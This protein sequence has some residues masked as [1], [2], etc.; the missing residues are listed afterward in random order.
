MHGDRRQPLLTC[1]EMEFLL[2]DLE[3]G[4]GGSSLPPPSHGEGE[5]WRW[6]GTVTG[7]ADSCTWDVL[8]TLGGLF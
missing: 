2:W 8:N 5:L 6:D 7:N 4:A 3:A 1:V